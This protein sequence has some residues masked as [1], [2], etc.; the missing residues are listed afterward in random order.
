MPTPSP[1]SRS[2]AKSS[3]SIAAVASRV[4]LVTIP[5]WCAD[6]MPPQT[7]GVR[8]KSSALTMSRRLTGASPR[9]GPLDR[10]ALDR[11]GHSRRQGGLQIVGADVLEA[12]VAD[13][14]ERLGLAADD[15][16]GQARR[17]E[18]GERGLWPEEREDREDQPA[19]RHEV[20]RCAGDHAVEQL[21]A[22]DAAVVGGRRRVAP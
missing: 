6:R 19:S 5:W 10:E 9:R 16:G 2:A 15:G 22:V 3:S 7:P 20:P 21:P 11:L 17:F 4:V 8:P 18:L 12:L 14:R 1:E 13:A